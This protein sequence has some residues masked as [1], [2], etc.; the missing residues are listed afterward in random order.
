MLWRWS[1]PFKQ[2]H[3]LQEAEIRNFGKNLS[4]QLVRDSNQLKK[5]N[6]CKAD[7][8]KNGNLPKIDTFFGTKRIKPNSVDNPLK[9]NNITWY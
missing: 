6:F 7:M 3:P 4:L 1:T 5:R 8:I 9:V 2:N